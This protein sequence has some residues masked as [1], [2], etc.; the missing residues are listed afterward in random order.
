MLTYVTAIATA[1][2]LAISPLFVSD[3]ARDAKPTRPAWQ[4]VLRNLAPRVSTNNTTISVTSRP[5][6]F[7][8]GVE[9]SALRRALLR[10]VEIVSSPA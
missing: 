5:T 9:Q 1:A 6:Y 2:T 3:C 8:S 10:S 4:E 7:L